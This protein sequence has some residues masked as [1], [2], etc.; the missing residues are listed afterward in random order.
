MYEI[1][2][3]LSGETVAKARNNIR[4]MA[5]CDEI[6]ETSSWLGRKTTFDVRFAE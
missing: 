1:Y 5:L 3:T 2:D 6:A 4:A